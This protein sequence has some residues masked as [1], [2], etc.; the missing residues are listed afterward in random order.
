MYPDSAGF[1]T[2]GF[3][4]L[5]AKR[6]CG[7][8]E[9]LE[10]RLGITQVRGEELLLADLGTAQN[11]VAALVTVSMNDGQFGALVDFVFNVGSENFK[12]ST[13][14]K[15][16]NTQ[17]FGEVPGQFRRWILVN[18]KPTAGLKK[19]REREVDLFFDELLIPA[20]TPRPGEDLSPIDIR[21][22]EAIRP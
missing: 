13:L 11:T 10:F 22:G 21:R 18:G 4:H 3:G 9:P 17:Q 7:D 20:A 15:R 5:I 19:R 16:V 8:D 14:V 2:I 6:A 1:C 12:T